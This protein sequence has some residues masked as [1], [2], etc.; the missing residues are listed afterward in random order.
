M[1]D[2]N[3][4]QPGRD[5]IKG[6]IFYGSNLT[7]SGTFSN[8]PNKTTVEEDTTT[9]KP[10]M[11]ITLEGIKGSLQ[12]AAQTVQGTKD[13]VLSDKSI[14]NYLT[15]YVQLLIDYEDVR[16]LVF[17][18]SSYNEL[19]ENINQ[20][21]ATFP[22][23]AALLK[24]EEDLFKIEAFPNLGISDFYFRDSD[25]FLSG[26]LSFDNS[27]KTTWTKKNSTDKSVGYEFVD[28]N[29]GRY[30]ILEF[31]NSLKKK[32]IEA[33]PYSV[34]FYE[35]TIEKTLELLVGDTISFG[36]DE[37]IGYG[38]IVKYT[39]I[40]IPVPY[41]GATLGSNANVLVDRTKNWI[42]DSLVGYYV[43]INDNY[44]QILSNTEDTLTLQNDARIFEGDFY[45]IEGLL[46]DPIN[47]SITGQTTFFIRYT[48]ILFADSHATGGSGDGVD[49]YLIDSTKNWEDGQWIGKQVSIIEGVGVGSLLKI[50]D[51]YR[52]VDGDCT[53]QLELGPGS[54]DPLDSTTRY[55]ILEFPEEFL[56]HN[57]DPDSQQSCTLPQTIMKFTVEGLLSLDNM[58]IYTRT[59]TDVLKGFLISPTLTKLIDFNS[60]LSGI[61]KSLINTLNPT[62]WPREPL[63][64]NIIISGADFTNWI[65][66]PYNMTKIWEADEDFYTGENL[67]YNLLGAITLDETKTNQLIRRC[68]PYEIISE[69]NDTETQY[70]QRF[71]LLAGKMF[72]TL[73][74]Y[75]DFVRYVHTLNYTKTNQLSPEFYKEYAE[76][77][78]FS[79]FDEDTTDLAKTIIYGD[80]L[81]DVSLT[82]SFPDSQNSSSI[83]EIIAE[84]QKLLLIN[85]LHLYQTKG[86]VDCLYF[87]TNLLGAPSGLATVQEFAF[88]SITGNRL[89]DND[90]V[91]VPSIE[92]V[93]DET[94][95]ID[96]ANPN[97]PINYP[98]VY[99]YKLSN[100]NIT[101]LREV[102]FGLDPLQ[103]IILDIMKYGETKTPKGSFQGEAFADLQNLKKDYYLLP[104]SFPDKYCGI[105]VNYNIPREGM[106][107]E[108]ETTSFN[109]C[110]LYKVSEEILP[111]DPS[112]WTKISFNY[113]SMDPN[114]DP[115]YYEVP[116]M[117]YQEYIMV[118]L[119]G[120]DLVV[121]LCL[122]SETTGISYNRI[123]VS[124]N[125]FLNDGLTHELKLL[126]RPKGMEIYRDGVYFDL[127]GW[128]D[129]LG[130][131]AKL[132]SKSVIFDSNYP[133]V[134]LLG[135]NDD[136]FETPSSTNN[137]LNWWNMFT[138]YSIGVD[139]LISRISIFE[140]L[141][142]N[143]SDTTN[144]VVNPSGIFNEKWVFDFNNQAVDSSLNYLTNEINVSCVYQI[145]NPNSD[146]L[147][148]QHLFTHSNLINLV[149]KKGSSGIVKFELDYMNFFK[150]SSGN[151]I[152]TAEDLFKYNAHSLTLH[153]DYQY[154]KLLSI[155]ESYYSYADAALTYI[156]LLPFIETVESKFRKLVEQFLP[157]VINLTSFGRITK[158]YF[159]KVRYSKTELYELGTRNCTTQA[160][161][162]VQSGTA[163]DT[164]PIVIDITYKRSD[165]S[166]IDFTNHTIS[167]YKPHNFA[168]GETVYLSGFNSADGLSNTTFNPSGSVVKMDDYTI[169]L[170]GAAWSG[171]WDGSSGE[172]QLSE[173]TNIVQGTPWTVS[174][175]K[176]VLTMAGAIQGS[177]PELNPTTDENTLILSPDLN[178]WE[179]DHHERS[180][181][182]EE[183]TISCGPKTV[184]VLH[185]NFN[186]GCFGQQGTDYLI[187]NYSKPQRIVRKNNPYIY[188]ETENKPA[189]YIYYR[190]ENKDGD[191][192]YI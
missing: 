65:E 90:K 124:P 105:S 80:Q 10:S 92:M 11:R 134:P 87:L 150:D 14:N 171:T 148:E 158:N 118:R 101:N 13:D 186:S 163:Q 122:V 93:I 81:T 49:N 176:T 30:S 63:T 187:V 139:V 149:S 184:I 29:S 69:L 116:N 175:I 73:K 178:Q 28:K 181:L 173:L 8:I 78:G 85:L 135:A 130:E 44:W 97:N 115:F 56:G 46:N 123:A 67:E 168:T 42:I 68:I 32:I 84:K 19:V 24:K 129:T 169:S 147:V 132:V 189:S 88:D 159:T 120:K 153:S 110:G 161:L 128:K 191:L 64:E 6:G 172:V 38:R 55:L 16:N 45:I 119:E 100:Q 50:V 180:L 22:F 26:G 137:V 91:N 70:F 57:A 76:H 53:L 35:V 192:L 41:G 117:S 126:F 74:V 72:D 36:T 43:E 66:N 58:L 86:T 164:T 157:I 102:S 83:K 7:P 166:C 2:V 156:N 9:L 60:Q 89:I 48:P 71:I 154:D 33:T 125:F 160:M 4:Q 145:S 62:P 170:V 151:L 131:S 40:A 52:N 146:S 109:L 23:R 1:A 79:L 82:P 107:K 37:Q 113:P 25:I 39:P 183:V 98:Y 34:D 162:E 155:V 108:S 136:V 112:T 165:I 179:L 95:L 15:T 103:A 3:N 75:I 114:T 185:S 174:N 12:K 190:E 121:R 143:E 133:F 77:Y 141:F 20:V 31:N 182:Q 94:Y 51:N 18:G 177:C 111:L 127:V 61:S 142:V 167:F 17:F 21:K 106:K 188:Y 47:N 5:A 144:I 54:L 27:G 140:N 59:A 138:G 96:V 99:K 104:L 152:S